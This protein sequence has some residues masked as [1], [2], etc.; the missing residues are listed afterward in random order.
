MGQE[1]NKFTK[2]KTICAYALDEMSKSG[3]GNMDK[4]WLFAF[5]GLM[6]IGFEISFE[7]QTFRLPVL[8]NKTAT[9]PAGSLGVTKVA[10]LN[11][12]GELVA[13][14]TNNALTKWNDL[15]PNR[16]G[17]L[18]PNINNSIDDISNPS[19]FFNYY[20]N[21]NYYN[22]YG[23]RT[24]IVTYG[25]CTIDEKNGVI[26]LD[27]NFQYD[28]VMVECIIAP[29]EDNDYMI[30]TCLQEALIEWIKLKFKMGTQDDYTRAVIKGRRRLQ[31]KKV[32]LA[33]VNQVIRESVAMKILS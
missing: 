23:V 28:N 24:G 14:K 31:N 11:E 12:N 4:A 1:I 5:R 27:P 10:L 22:L 33:T 7:P 15:N 20:N 26:V 16:L 6:D 19:W 2:L 30:E 21:G 3:T 29:Q 25:A 18:T 32:N 9:I 8:G 13:L 17:L